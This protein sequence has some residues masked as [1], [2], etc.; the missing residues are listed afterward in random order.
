M[1]LRTELSAEHEAL[2]R[3]VQAGDPHARAHRGEATH[4][5]GACTLFLKDG[6]F[7]QLITEC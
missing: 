5:Q 1:C 7:P 2:Q 3:Q 4:L 6:R